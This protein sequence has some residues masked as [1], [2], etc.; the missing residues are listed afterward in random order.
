MS[1]TTNLARRASDCD[2]GATKLEALARYFTLHPGTWL[3]AR[4]LARVGGLLSWRTRVSELR[5]QPYGFDIQN[6]VRRQRQT[7]GRPVAISEYRL[8]QP[9]QGAGR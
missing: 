3:D 1:D 4:H 9:G 7:D 5:Q 2:C 6:R 8:R